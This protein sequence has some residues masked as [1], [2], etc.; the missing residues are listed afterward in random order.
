MAIV[1]PPYGDSFAALCREFCRLMAQVF[2]QC[3]LLPPCGASF[4]ALWPSTNNQS[5]VQ[6]SVAVF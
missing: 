6:K 3:K 4:A 2:P 5:A 1:L